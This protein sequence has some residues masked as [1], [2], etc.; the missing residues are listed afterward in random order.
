MTDF[1]AYAALQE[2]FTELNHAV[3]EFE[4]DPRVTAEEALAHFGLPGG[5]IEPL[6]PD[7]EE[8]GVAHE[9]TSEIYDWDDPWSISYGIDGSTTR[10]LQFSNGLL[11]GASV[12]KL[13]VSGDSDFADLANQAT[14]TLV[15][16]LNEEEFSLRDIDTASLDIS[17]GIDAHLFQFP[18]CERTSRLEEYVVEVSRT[19][20]EGRHAFEMA[21]EIDGPLFIDGPLYP[22]PAFGWML[23]EQV[24]EGPRRMTKIWPEMVS[25]ILQNYVKTVEIMHRRDLP[26]VGITKTSGSAVALDTLETKIEAADVDVSVPLPWT[27]DH[28]LFNDALFTMEDK[29]G[30]RGSLISYTPWLLQTR[31]TVRGTPVV[32][33]ETFDIELEHGD[34]REYQRAFFYARTP[35]TD[36]VMR[37]EAPYMQVREQ[38]QRERIQQK[39]LV[40]LAQQQKE[41]RAITHADE[42]A[43]ITRGDRNNLRRLLG[44][45]RALEDYNEKR[46][47]R[48]MEAE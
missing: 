35:M 4:D 14:T 3:G 48:D 21:G 30:D 47:F 42:M 1:G 7:D 33:F 25:D 11:V 23:F 34:A 40:E 46:G 31:Q 2:M 37:V 20:A 17:E 6:L 15:A 36:N 41:P 43:R 9:P 32:P 16:H 27:N 22:N 19:Y 8:F 38:S 13:G 5:H 39:L 28:Q 26:I 44:S 24:G 29:H 18:P 12:A 45:V 10:S